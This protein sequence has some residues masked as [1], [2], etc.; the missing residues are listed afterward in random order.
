MRSLGIR[1]AAGAAWL[2]AA[3]VPTCS[4]LMVLESMEAR[5][6]PAARAAHDQL[7]RTEEPDLATIS[8]SAAICSPNARRPVFLSRAEV[9]GRLPTNAL[10]SI[11][12]ACSRSEEHTSEL[13]S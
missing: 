1:R 13:Q 6:M 2:P 4:V 11:Y 8:C 12:P 3:S 7:G 9:R 10:R 5:R